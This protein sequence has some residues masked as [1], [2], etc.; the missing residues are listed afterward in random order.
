[1]A[2]VKNCSVYE[3]IYYM[4]NLGSQAYMVLVPDGKTKSL[5][6]FNHQHYNGD[7]SRSATVRK[8]PHLSSV[9]VN[10]SIL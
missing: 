9:C 2:K 3:N 6:R 4:F 8:S 1:M 7:I 5:P 10:P